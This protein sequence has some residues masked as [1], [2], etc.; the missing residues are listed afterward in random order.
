MPILD[1]V[2]FIDVAEIY[3]LIWA[4]YCLTLG[5]LLC[6][7]GLT[8]GSLLFKSGLTLGSTSE[9]FFN[10]K[11]DYHTRISRSTYEDA[12]LILESIFSI[13]EAEIF[14]L[15]WARYCLTLGS[16]LCKSGLTLGSLLFKSGLTLGSTFEPFLQHALSHINKFESE[17]RVSP[18]LNN[19]EPRVSPE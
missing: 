5:S 17:P 14:C 11:I 1:S 18:D 10:S 4:R 12:K 7:S 8:L 3:C 13:D 9:Y 16:L 6:K 19:S 2:V 15:I